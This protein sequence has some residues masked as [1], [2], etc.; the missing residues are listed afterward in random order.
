M[1]ALNPWAGRRLADHGSSEWQLG[2]Y[3]GWL[4]P[5]STRDGTLSVEMVEVVEMRAVAIAR[6]DNVLVLRGSCMER[7]PQICASL[8]DLLHLLLC[9]GHAPLESLSMSLMGSSTM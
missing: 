1:P 9:S 4:R 8:F 2:S 5:G 7:A 6:Y 3:A